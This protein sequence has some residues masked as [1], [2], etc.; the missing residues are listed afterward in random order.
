MTTVD[1]RED[2]KDESE[3]DDPNRTRYRR[4]SRANKARI[5]KNLHFFSFLLIPKSIINANVCTFVSY[6]FFCKIYD[7]RLYKIR[8]RIL[9]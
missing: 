1:S 2:E 4:G 5:A 6:S 9:F 8:S 3:F 7:F